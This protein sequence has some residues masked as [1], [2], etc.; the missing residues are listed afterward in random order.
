[1]RAGFIGCVHSSRMALETLLSIE[2]I[3]V[4]AVV[5]KKN[6]AVNADFC[7]LS[8]VCYDRNIPFHYEDSKNKTASKA[9]LSDFD[10]DIIYCVGWSYLLDEEL[11]AMP[12]Q[13]II[14][15]HPAKLPQ[16][17]GRHPII[18]ALALGL[19]ETAS[20]FFKMDSGADSGPI[21]SQER[22]KIDMDENAQSLYD[23]ILHTAQQQI[24][25][26]TKSLLEGSAVFAEQ[27]Q[28][29][30]TYWRKRSR[31]DGLIDFRMSAE[32]IHNLVRALAPPYPC[33][34]FL[35]KENLV[36]VRRSE[37]LQQTVP[38]NIEPGKV[39]ETRGNS[40]LVKAAGTQAIWLHD[41]VLEDIDVGDYL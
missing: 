22:I 27:D 18:W 29:S 37:I 16:N 23:K 32:S 17:R 25:D 3:E 12:K 4:C 35:Y 31:K 34:E 30:A 38:A 21:I 11:L 1:M 2:G 5:T 39:L 8:P 6:S 28:Q 26:F 41:A 36:Q 14:G 19:S 15:F 20:T 33:A 40:I 13:G 24:K 10:L 7:D 9:F